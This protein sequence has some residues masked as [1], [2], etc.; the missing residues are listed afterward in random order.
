MFL[1]LSYPT[2]I[3]VLMDL[4]AQNAWQVSILTSFHVLSFF[5]NHRKSYLCSMHSLQM[6]WMHRWSCMHKMS[7][8]LL[9]EHFIQSVSVMHISLYWMWSKWIRMHKMSVLFIVL[10]Q[11]RNT[12]LWFVFPYSAKLSHMWSSRHIMLP[13]HIDSV[14][15]WLI[16]KKMCYMCVSLQRLSQ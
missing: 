8:W 5:I 16:N 7:I 1:V 14:L 9:F 3:Y 4:I 11:H 15:C 2:V 13:M 10:T 6:S 12:N